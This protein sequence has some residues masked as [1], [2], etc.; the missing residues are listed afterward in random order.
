MGKHY[1]PQFLPRGFTH[2]GRVHVYD[3]LTTEWLRSQPMPV[4]NE[5]NL[6]PEEVETFITEQVEQPAQDAIERLRQRDVLT[7]RDRLIANLRILRT[8]LASSNSTTGQTATMPQ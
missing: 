8:R 1:V 6:C 4:A 2:E 5:R 7:E 3:K